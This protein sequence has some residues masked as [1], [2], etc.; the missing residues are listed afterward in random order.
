MAFA[1]AL[2]PLMA[3]AAQR[4]ERS[5]NFGGYCAAKLSLGIE[6]LRRMVPK[7]PLRQS[8]GGVIVTNNQAPFLI[9]SAAAAMFDRS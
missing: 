5:A 2:P 7:D 8:M 4:R 3:M 6:P 1:R 9:G